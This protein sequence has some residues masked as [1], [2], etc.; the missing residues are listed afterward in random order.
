MPIRLLL[1]A[2]AETDATRRGT[3]P[4]GD[5]LN[6]RGRSAANGAAHALPS[7]TTVLTSPAAAAVETAL[8]FGLAAQEEAALGDLDVGTWAGQ[9]V[10]DI[11]M[12]DPE[13]ATAWIADPAFDGHGGESFLAL[14]ARVARWLDDLRNGDGIVI[15]ITHAALIRAAVV[16]VLDA[17]ASGFWRIDV[18]PLAALTLSGDGRRWTMRELR[19]LEATDGPG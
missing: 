16:A 1:V 17:P 6:A 13:G 14:V 19:R 4:A 11:G 5:G 9:S 12:T 7:A 15:A 18:A 8:A 2:H 3:F 10:M